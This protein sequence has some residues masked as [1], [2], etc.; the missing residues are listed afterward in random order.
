[1]ISR[2]RRVLLINAKTSGTECSGSISEIDPREGAAITGKN[3]AGKTT[4]LQLIPLF[5]GSSPNHIVQSGGTREHMLRFV[6]PHPQCAVVFEYQRGNTEDD[7]RLSILRRQDGS[8]APEYRFIEGPFR[9]ELFIEELA[10][11]SGAV[12]LNDVGTVD[13]ANNLGLVISAKI[14]AAEYRRII[15]NIPSPNKDADKERTAARKYSFSHKKLPHLDRLVSSMVKEKVDFK[16]F[17]AVAVTMV[18]DQMGGFVGAANAPQKLT[19]RQGKEQIQR[20]L[21]NRD[22]CERALKAKDDVEALRLMLDRYRE[23]VIAMRELRADVQRLSSLLIGYKGARAN[24]LAELTTQYTHQSQALEESLKELRVRSTELDQAHAKASEIYTRE[25]SLQN[26]YAEEEAQRW[27]L[28]VGRLPLLR[29]QKGQTELQMESLKGVA[30]GISRKFDS[31]IEAVKRGAAETRLKME[32][33][34]KKFDDQY[35]SELSSISEQE[36]NTFEALRERHRLALDTQQAILNDLTEASAELKSEVS[37]P[38]VGPGYLR[39]QEDAQ[40]DLNSHNDALVA[41][42]AQFSIDQSDLN[43]AKV[44][45]D[46]CEL[47]AG[48]QKQSV[49]SA[50][51]ALDSAKLTLA[52]PEGSLHAALMNSSDDSW[53]TNLARVLNPDILLNKDLSPALLD[54]AAST[55]YGWTLNLGTLEN[56]DWTNDDAVKAK[57]A[58][59]AES[60]ENAQFRLRLVQEEFQASSAWFSRATAVFE[61]SKANQSVL[62][63]KTDYL[64]LQVTDCAEAVNSARKDAAA[65]A[66]KKLDL[67]TGQQNT[68]K[69]ELLRLHGAQTKE[70]SELG[71]EFRIAREQALTRRNSANTTVD[72]QVRNYAAEQVVRVKQIEAARDSKLQDEGVDVVKLGALR[73]ELSGLVAEIAAISDKGPLVDAWQKWV[74]A[75]GPSHLEGLQ[76]EAHRLETE[77]SNAA[78]AVRTTADVIEAAQKA[79]AVNKRNISGALSKLEGEIED[80]GRLDAALHEFFPALGSKMTEDTPAAELRGRHNGLRSEFDKMVSDIE[81]KYKRLDQTL[82]AQDSA[83]KDFI[84]LCLEDLGVDASRVE[85][86]QRLAQS[87]DRIGREVIGP[88]NSELSTIL[89]HISQFRKQIQRFESEVKSFNNRLQEGLNGVVVGFDRLKDF[90]IAVVTDFAKIDFMDKLKSLDD[91]VRAHREQPRATYTLDVPSASAAYVL[92]DFM[93]VLSNGSLEIDLSQHITLSGSVNDEGNVKTFHRESELENLSSTGITA[94]ALITMLSGMLNVIR[95]TEPIYIPW[96]TD[97]VTR[98]DSDNFSNLMNM[99]KDNKIDVV[100]ASP[101]LTPASYEFFAHRYLFGRK[102]SIAVYK[103]VIRPKRV[104]GQPLMAT[105]VAA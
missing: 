76:V 83:V 36:V 37:N 63:G 1:M 101:A 64:K 6:L 44:S 93:S 62:Q 11:G 30:D 56:P 28:E 25:R 52:P 31:E 29:D 59:C 35:Q 46:R 33:G 57:I 94:I 18:L 43:A 4:T 7:V 95:G 5:L 17:T 78:Q 20:W 75:S 66:R 73:V 34:K 45:F 91:V 67:A 98:F 68:A 15:L 26:Y 10:D 22:A 88:V 87:Y 8:D 82:T 21:K 2:L 96:V 89:S 61:E 86:A 81:V 40:R 60:L 90:K 58:D 105:E 50:Q 85:R 80:L 79:Y 49:A 102:G 54:E 16:D 104:L 84:T 32:E 39:S 71:K 19:V 48:N 72:A 65:A 9:Q 51:A 3:G 100:T 14:S 77:K 47:A 55:L 24:E 53:K 23:K 38:V 13:A 41:V 74:N 103:N 70:T 99:L 27:S 92:Q 97:E 12:F 42:Q 69:S